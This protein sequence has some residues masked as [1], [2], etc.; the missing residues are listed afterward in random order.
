VQRV[1]ENL[2]IVSIR[3]RER[4]G[5][6]RAPM[7]V[8]VPWVGITSGA[9]YEMHRKTGA[10]YKLIKPMA[11]GALQ[12]FDIRAK[13]PTGFTTLGNTVAQTPIIPNAGLASNQGYS[14]T[15]HLHVAMYTE[16]N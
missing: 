12:K 6:F 9:V 13:W 1:F 14:V 11:V 5:A 16:V 4:D 10:F 8:L 7:S 2:S 3:H 15:M